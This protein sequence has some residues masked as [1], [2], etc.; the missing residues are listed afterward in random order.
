MEGLS[1]KEA[2]CLSER[3]GTKLV[4]YSCNERVWGSANTHHGH[5]YNI[6]RWKGKWAVHIKSPCNTTGA[7]TQLF[8]L[9]Q[10]ETKENSISIHN[11]NTKPLLRAQQLNVFIY[12]KHV[13]GLQRCLSHGCL[14][15][16]PIQTKLLPSSFCGCPVVKVRARA[17]ACCLGQRVHPLLWGTSPD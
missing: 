1:F 16:K 6:P 12:H 2:V 9:K 7:T 10:N 13:T 15:N 3:S 4:I 8:Q 5:T 14:Q 11:I 17:G